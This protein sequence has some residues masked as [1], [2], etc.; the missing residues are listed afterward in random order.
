VNDE[1]Q[2]ERSIIEAEVFLDENSALKARGRNLTGRSIYVDVGH[3]EVDAGI[4][5]VSMSVRWLMHGQLVDGKLVCEP[6]PE[7][8]AAEPEE[9]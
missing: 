2:P 6:P 7:P 1:P 8:P 5:E 9:P 4:V 3:R